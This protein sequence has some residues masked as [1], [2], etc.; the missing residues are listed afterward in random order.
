VDTEVEV[1]GVD[2]LPSGRRVSVKATLTVAHP[3]AGKE[4]E[5]SDQV[6][7]ATDENQQGTLAYTH[8]PV[9][10]IFLTTQRLW[11]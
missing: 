2:D 6:P 5:K 9:L 11:N 3:T 10:L 8:S 1:V 4:K 7:A